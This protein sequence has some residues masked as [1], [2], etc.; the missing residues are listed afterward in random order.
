MCRVFGNLID[1]ACDAIED[2]GVRTDS[3]VRVTLGETP[4]AYVFS[5]AN[6]GPR[7]P[8]GALEDIF[9]EGFTTK[10][11]GHG[12]GLSIVS[13][14]LTTYGGS[15]EVSSDDAETRFSGAIPKPAAMPSRDK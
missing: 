2:A 8:A 5:V 14:I 15:I 9:H 11:D 3:R 12:T 1:N 4:G 10:A 13:E 7:I 6:N